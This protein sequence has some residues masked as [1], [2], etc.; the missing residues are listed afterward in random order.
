MAKK[1]LAISI[2]ILLLIPA[3]PTCAADDTYQLSNTKYY[4]VETTFYVTNKGSSTARNITT[5]ITYGNNSLSR[6]MPYSVLM[7]TSFSPA[8]KS[9]V[10]DE[11]GNEK[12]TFT[13]AS[14]KP[15]QTQTIHMA[16]NYK[17][18]SID[19]TI[20]PEN[21]GSYEPLI[22]VLG[23][24]LS[25]SPGI[26]SDNPQIINK[27]MEVTQGETNPYEKAKKIFTFI[28][29]HM[30]YDEE[31]INEER[32]KG[33]LEALTT[34]RGVCE[35]Y[36]DLMVA[37]LRA[38]GVP[39]RTVVG[40]MGDVEDTQQVIADRSGILLPGHVWVEYY[41]PG[42]GWVPADPTYTFLVNGVSMVDYSRLTGFN[43]LRFSEI[44][45]AKDNVISYSYYGD[46]ELEYDIIVKASDTPFPKEKVTRPV[47]MYLEDIPL[48]FDVDPLIVEGHTLVPMRGM[49]KAMGASVEWDAKT[50]RVTAREEGS[51]VILEIGSK[52]AWINGESVSL[53]TAPVI[54]GNRTLIPLRFAGESLGKKVI[55]D[56]QTRTINIKMDEAVNMNE[57]FS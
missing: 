14:L 48:I 27:A 33:A 47:V 16:R 41:L 53:D 36:A 50:K 15:K 35:D 45:E 42:Y 21:I 38:V 55:W 3:L 43:T 44:S 51:I 25:P 1:F 49:F 29:E 57:D 54:Y 8:P 52:T 24:Y 46:V 4:R 30:T 18:S 56:G 2:I 40:W 12:G 20:D 23:L 5:Q 22:N 10:K 6:N 11:R 26:E 7:S 28:K 17:V 9:V 34:G 13:I 37:M 19:Y 39:S 32:D 31:V